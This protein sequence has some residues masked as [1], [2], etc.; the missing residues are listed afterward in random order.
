MNFKKNLGLTLKNFLNWTE[1]SRAEFLF[2]YKIPK[3]RLE[4]NEYCQLRFNKD[5]NRSTLYFRLGVNNLEKQRINGADVRI[6]NIEKIEKSNYVK[7]NHFNPF[8]LHWAN[9]KTDNS[10]HISYNTTVFIDFIRTMNTHPN[11]AFLYPKSKHVGINYCITPGNWIVTIKLTAENIQPIEKKI[12]IDFN[13]IWNE[14]KIKQLAFEETALKY[15]LKNRKSNSDIIKRDIFLFFKKNKAIIFLA[16]LSVILIIFLSSNGWK[17]NEI[18]FLN[19]ITMT[20]NSLNSKKYSQDLLID[21]E[22]TYRSIIITGWE[23]DGDYLGYL[24]Q[25]T[26][27]Y[28]RHQQVF[29]KEY[30]TYSRQLNEWQ[31]YFKNKRDN[32][33]FIYSTDLEILE[34][35][36]TSGRDHLQKISEGNN[37]Q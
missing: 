19:T 31:D 7:L 23:N 30:E 14:I 17:I 20:N 6:E 8:F 10:R 12:E 15:K 11:L 29:S 16:M 22:N 1:N 18:N 21:A 4:D 36:V 28:Q 5:L 9:E 13:G 24:V 25:I 34:G 35:L 33:S 37:N 3:T 27:F 32:D 26:G 2:E